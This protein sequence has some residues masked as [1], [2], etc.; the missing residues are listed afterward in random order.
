LPF[1]DELI[2]ANLH[3]LKHRLACG[4]LSQDKHASLFT[5]L[6]K[7]CLAHKSALQPWMYLNP[8]GPSFRQIQIAEWGIH[9]L[10]RIVIRPTVDDRLIMVFLRGLIASAEC[11]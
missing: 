4:K 10:V 3:S 7:F 9:D 8:A 5:P 6:P 2:S 1:L 11:L